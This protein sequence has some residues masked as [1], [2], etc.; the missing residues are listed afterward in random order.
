MISNNI[1]RTRWLWIVLAC[2]QCLQP[3]EATEQGAFCR[4]CCSHYLKTKNGQLDL[5]LKSS[6]K[7]MVPFVLTPSFTSNQKKFS[8]LPV[9]PNPEGNF[10][11]PNGI[12]KELAT[13]IPK[14]RS[15]SSLMLDLGCG[16]ARHKQNF[17]EAGFKYV[18][19]DYYSNQ[20]TLLG[21]A[22]ALPFQ[23][24]CFDFVFSRSV[25]EHLQYPLLAMNETYRVM[26]PNSKFIGS[27]PFLEPFH[28]S[29]CHFTHLGLLNCLESAGFTVEHISPHPT[30]DVL[31]AQ[32]SMSLFPKM[33]YA[34]SK[35]LVAPLRS[36][37]KIWW[38]IGKYVNP[39]ACELTRLL[40]TAGSFM[41]IASKT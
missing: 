33:P 3:L 15:N 14:A 21:D 22:H 41:F 20:A 25:I 16:D 6:K 4:S 7:V 10:G 11:I 9:N 36:L 18:G 24:E 2:P 27:A 26:K 39:E 29:F 37:H 31:T 17:T 1:E 34:L 8:I 23:N 40:W 5:R 28:N 35:T 13:Y 30:W 38:R 12:T 32:A 19:L